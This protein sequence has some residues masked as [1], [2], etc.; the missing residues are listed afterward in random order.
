M[1][2]SREGTAVLVLIVAALW[3]LVETRVVSAVPLSLPCNSTIAVPLS[4]SFAVTG[5]E[6]PVSITVTAAENLTLSASNV[7]V[8]GIALGNSPL[9]S[10][11]NFT[12]RVDNFTAAAANA[13]WLTV[14][15]ALMEDAALLL[16][17]GSVAVEYDA[18]PETINTTG[19]QVVGGNVGVV[20]FSPPQP[21]SLVNVT[22]AVER[23][24]VSVQ[25][26]YSPNV[27]LWLPGLIASRGVVMLSMSVRRLSWG[28]V[29][30][31]F[32]LVFCFLYYLFPFPFLFVV[33]F[34][35]P[36]LFVFICC[37]GPFS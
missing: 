11:T 21:T 3:L 5:C 33:L 7:T 14:V 15:C 37:S 24:D 4:G 34:G 32:F 17:N 28:S 30:A 25:S 9:S 23:V 8:A 2:G 31:A 22:I 35:P 29:C 27:V 26:T 13:S 20:A 1:R 18:A 16:S 19:G 36:F 12:L 10:F 6:G